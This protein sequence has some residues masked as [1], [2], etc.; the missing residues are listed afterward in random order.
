[1]YSLASGGV[2]ESGFYAPRGAPRLE[3]SGGKD[4]P[5]RRAR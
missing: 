1:V 2:K 5:I 3:S 4:A